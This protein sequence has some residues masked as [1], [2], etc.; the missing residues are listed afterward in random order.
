MVNDTNRLKF[1]KY[2]IQTTKMLK[3]LIRTMKMAAQNCGYVN[4]LS[5]KQNE[6][7]ERTMGANNAQLH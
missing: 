2:I 4:L 7:K 6:A 3:N 5:N 1:E